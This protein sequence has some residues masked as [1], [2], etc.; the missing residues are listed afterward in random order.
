[1]TRDA[2]R[3]HQHGIEANV[4]DSIVGIPRQPRL[5]GGD[6]ADALSVS[7]RPGGII[8]RLARL[9]LDEHQQVGGAR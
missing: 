1:M 3:R 4:A 5:G 7:D 8:E 6:D 9:D 2:A